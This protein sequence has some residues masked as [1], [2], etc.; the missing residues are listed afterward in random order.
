MLGIKKPLEISNPHNNK[1]AVRARGCLPKREEGRGNEDM[2]HHFF[3]IHDPVKGVLCYSWA[4][5]QNPDLCRIRDTSGQEGSQGVTLIKQNQPWGRTRLLQAV[6]QAQSPKTCQRTP[7]Q[8]K[9]VT[10]NATQ[11]VILTDKQ[12]LEQLFC[13]GVG[14]LPWRT[15]AFAPSI[16]SS[17]H[18]K[19]KLRKM[20]DF[21]QQW[22]DQRIG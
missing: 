6:T 3:N 7:N 12:V 4:L 17:S 20:T 2:H 21:M 1:R 11:T 10:A 13:A 14:N 5:Q 9:R 18:G 22:E 19:G 16:P 15:P 8:D